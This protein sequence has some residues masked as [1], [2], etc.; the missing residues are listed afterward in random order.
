[1]FSDGFVDQFGGP[2]EKKF[3]SKPFKKLIFEISDKPMKEQKELLN[4]AYE[5]WRGNVEQL[6]DVV[7]LGVRI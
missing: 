5:N 1:M 2:K 4:T 7:V 3:K 6:D